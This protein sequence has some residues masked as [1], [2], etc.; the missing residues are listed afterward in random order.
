MT[1]IMVLLGEKHWTAQAVHMA[2]AI[3][4]HQGGVI[5]L[6]RMI[7]VQYAAWLGTDLGN[8]PESSQE[9][10][11]FMDYCTTAE[12]YGVNVCLS[13]MQY[14]TLHDAIAEAAEHLDADLVFATLPAM[15][16]GFWRKHLLRQLARHLEKQ[17]R[18]LV[19]LEPVP[20]A[21]DW[22]PSVTLPASKG[23][24]EGTPQLH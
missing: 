1:T 11:D 15:R 12:D 5:E 10:R 19:T 24:Q 7:P 3:A 17:Q 9:Y 20:G 16:I 23:Q 4:R 6:V 21:D 18:T 22:T 8:F 2:S 14:H 13:Q